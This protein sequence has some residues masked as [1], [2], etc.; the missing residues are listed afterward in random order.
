MSATQRNTLRNIILALI[1]IGAVL[2]VTSCGDNNSGG[3]DQP[4]VS[5]PALPTCAQIGDALH[6]LVANL[7]P[8]NLNRTQEDIESGAMC[9]W[10][11]KPTGKSILI[12]AKYGPIDVQEIYDQKGVWDPS[13]SMMPVYSLAK[14]DGQE[15]SDAVFV[16]Y[17]G[18]AERYEPGCEVNLTY[19]TPKFK[20]QFI[21]EEYVIDQ[22][23]DATLRVADLMR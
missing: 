16:I 1:M 11:D 12:G 19:F 14:P 13:T 20:V 21:G 5:A 6:G 10:E 2:M 8:V 7:E 15:R 17:D 3:G 4:A 18:S 23:K 9:R 22:A